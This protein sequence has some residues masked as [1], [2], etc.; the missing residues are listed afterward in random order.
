MSDRSDSKAEMSENRQNVATGDEKSAAGGDSRVESGKA[1][2]PKASGITSVPALF[3]YAYSL[4]GKQVKVPRAV[5]EAI[6]S[7]ED[8]PPAD[9]D[10]SLEHLRELASGDPLLAVPPRLLAASEASND[11]RLL[12]QQL[13]GLLISA[14][15]RHRVFRSQKVQAVLAAETGSIDDAFVSVGL[16]SS[17]VSATDL[18]LESKGLKDSDRER[19]RVNAI[20]SLA[21]LLSAR[22][23]WSIAEL[24]ERLELHLW[25]HVAKRPGTRR[26]RVA[27]AESSNLDA[28]EV[29]A[30]IF[31]AQAESAR[32]AASDANERAS[33][34]ERYA[35][36]AR[37]RV[38]A[39]DQRTAQRESELV[40]RR[41]EITALEARIKELES[42][43]DA[44]RRNRVIDMSHHVDDYETLRT[45]VT[46]TLSRQID[47]L[48]DGLHAL[49]NGSLAVTEEYVDRSIDT[50]KTELDHLK[51]EGEDG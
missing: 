46:R 30:R 28:L 13:V 35:A 5:F 50:L 49:R 26:P 10:E 41:S 25:R 42:E 24:V 27:I 2:E 31:M 20:T 51:D 7:A 8:S 21:L 45:R 4:R 23:G 19:L 34:A 14:L 39:A 9:L 33:A 22:D 6:S 18:G 43:I 11:S 36:M 17:D 38:E 16:A 47:L 32:R 3:D 48:S 15:A 40:A 37:E 12:R 29:V 44:E 1:T